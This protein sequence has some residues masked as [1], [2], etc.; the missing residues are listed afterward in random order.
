MYMYM[1][2][3]LYLYMYTS[4][5]AHVQVLLSAGMYTSML[6]Y[7]MHTKTG[8]RMFAWIGDGWPGLPAQTGTGNPVLQ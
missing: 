3:S 4:V 7:I 1:Y 5:A 2:T 6:F 8:E